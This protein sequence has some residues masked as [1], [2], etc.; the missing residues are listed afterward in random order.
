MLASIEAKLIAFAAVALLLLGGYAW[1]NHRGAVSQQAA[2]AVV[3]GQKTQALAAAGQSLANAAAALRAASAATIANRD[4]AD[5]ARAIADAAKAHAAEAK[6]ALV[7]ANAAWQAKFKAAQGA[8]GCETLQE[9][10]CPAVFP[11]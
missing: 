8:K 2:D 11:Y 9:L 4:A 1:A 7:D 3:I 6:Q 5:A 10:L